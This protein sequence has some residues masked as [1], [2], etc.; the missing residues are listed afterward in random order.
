MFSLSIAPL[1]TWGYFLS[2]HLLL[3]VQMIWLVALPKMCPPTV[4]VYKDIL[5]IFRG[6]F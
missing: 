3:F 6:A 5:D 2:P 1:R 4:K